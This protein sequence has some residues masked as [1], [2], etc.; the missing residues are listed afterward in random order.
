M[1][2]YNYYFNMKYIT[3]RKYPFK[4]LYVV[5]SKAKYADYCGWKFAVAFCT[6]LWYLGL[7]PKYAFWLPLKFPKLFYHGE[8][9]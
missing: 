7:N 1:P 5:D 2:Y 6:W 3:I 9:D 4:G 8:T